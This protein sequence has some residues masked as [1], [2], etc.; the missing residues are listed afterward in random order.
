MDCIVDDEP[1]RTKATAS[2][3]RRVAAQP[4]SPSHTATAVA[5][6]PPRP[7]PTQR[8][9]A[10]QHV[11]PV[12]GPVATESHEER[13]EAITQPMTPVLPPPE[14][15]VVPA[16]E[17]PVVEPPPVSPLETPVVE[18]QEPIVEETILS[19]PV[20][21]P[22]M[23]AP[24]PAPPLEKTQPIQINPALQSSPEPIASEMTLP[25]LDVDRGE[26]NSLNSFDSFIA[27][28]AGAGAPTKLQLPKPGEAAEQMTP[29]DFIVPASAPVPSSGMSGETVDVPELSYEEE[30][31]PAAQEMP[32]QLTE[33][34]IPDLA[35]LDMSAPGI[36]MDELGESEA[37]IDLGEAMPPESE[38]FHDEEP[39]VEDSV[40]PVLI[41][42]HEFVQEQAAPLREEV[43][44]PAEQQMIHPAEQQMI[45]PAAEPGGHNDFI[46]PPVE[47]VTEEPLSGG[48]FENLLSEQVPEN[49]QE[50]QPPS[51][52]E[53]LPA[54]SDELAEMFGSPQR[55]AVPAAVPPPA[56]EESQS[57][58]E[59]F[60]V[61]EEPRAGKKK[62][63]TVVMLSMIG[64]VAVI[65]IVMVLVV[66]NALGGFNPQF[67]TDEEEITPPPTVREIPAAPMSPPTGGEPSI[68]DAPAVIDPVAQDRVGENPEGISRSTTTLPGDTSE[69][70][71]ISDSAAPATIDPPI[72]GAPAQAEAPALSFDE[73]VQQIVNG[74]S[75]AETNSS[76]MNVIGG[77]EAPIPMDSLDATIEGLTGAAT[78]AVDEVASVAE[79]ATSGPASTPVSNY[80][81]PASFPAPGPDDAP[82][83]KTHDLLD[84]FLRAPNWE[85]RVPYIYQGES[86]R[87][88]IEDY[89]KKW[90]LTAIDRF[91]LQLFQME[92]DV[93]LGG[94][95]W[96]YL[97]STSDVDQGYPVIIREEDGNLKV[98]WEIYSEFQDQHFVEFQKG[99]IASPHTF[100]LVI[101]RVSDYYGSDRDGFTNLDDF[102]V[103]QINP[104]YGDLSE[105]SEY[106]FVKKDS[107]LAAELEKV[108]GL[109][110]EPLAVILTVEQKAFA[111]GVKHI[112][113]T[114]YVTE[115]W[116]R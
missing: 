82:L 86:L 35:D 110:D 22:M 24:I 23:E 49:L 69:P 46:A 104:P 66:V 25:R 93:S 85:S 89:Y 31:I 68:S 112:E 80:N 17:A 13:P 6:A 29:G 67:A 71:R 102:Y 9:A 5:D 3:G 107:G 42:E 92:Q 88:A 38:G 40:A 16:P 84:A 101:E 109:N 53:N 74:T 114:D 47:E 19:Q 98:D 15:P 26:D 8:T 28:T 21:D 99:A 12:Q 52:N 97:V 116:F 111:H 70:V 39:I 48:S 78:A 65:S 115:G 61:D 100:R 34:V 32:P 27:S 56:E 2:T 90:P 64:G 106:A 113:I 87:P 73:R 20:S 79:A 43:I 18:E 1:P 41:P 94:P 95:Y 33:P 77:S 50:Y 51:A 54:Q 108:V 4:S 36:S 91:S 60:G 57:F 83:G 76:S 103:Y 58:D 45:H 59:L 37:P 62:L 72:T 96:V 75:G 10:P 55:E 14:A 81:P 30:A 105:F 44:Q 7:Q 63:T 11:G